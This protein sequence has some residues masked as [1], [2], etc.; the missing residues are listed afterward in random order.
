MT[1]PLPSSCLMTC[2]VK[3]SSE[4]CSRAWRLF[5]ELRFDEEEHGGTSTETTA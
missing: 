3:P 4:N 2:H 1:L 5:V